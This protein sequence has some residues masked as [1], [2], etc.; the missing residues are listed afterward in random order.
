MF[1][2]SQHIVKDNP[3]RTSAPCSRVFI[4][5]RTSV[6]CSCTIAIVHCAGVRVWC[7][8]ASVRGR[9]ALF[10]PTLAVKRWQGVPGPSSC[11]VARKN[12]VGPC[13]MRCASV[14]LLEKSAGYERKQR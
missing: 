11:A 9:A 10:L 8:V 13:P 1:R 14:W 3:E 2:E 5:E 6:P 4:S 12:G 7:V